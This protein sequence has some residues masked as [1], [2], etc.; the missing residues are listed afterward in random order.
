MRFSIF[1]A[2]A[3]LPALVLAQQ[4]NITILVGNSGLSYSPPNVTA[5]VGDIVTFEFRAKNHTV[6]Q[7]SFADP[8][9]LLVNTT[10]GTQGFNS[11]FFPVAA[12][13]SE[14]PTWSIQ[15][16]ADTPIWFYC[17][18]TGHCQQGMVG[19]I[20]AAVTG[21]K[22][23]ANFQASAMGTT[24]SSSSPAAASESPSVSGIYGSVPAGT[25]SA[26]SPAGSATPTGTK[27]GALPVAM[28]GT[29]AVLLVAGGLA[30][31]LLL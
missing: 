7:S 14:F 30:A 11:G 1:A 24:S 17:Q 26:S 8:C 13:A 6:T 31:G 3:A 29:G 23:F 9:S 19:A 18:Q 16:T 21:N 2:V 4:Q 20:N 25:G 5:S 22:T 15:I 27:S 28:G 10:T 12:N